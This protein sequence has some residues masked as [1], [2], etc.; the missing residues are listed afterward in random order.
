[1]SSKLNKNNFKLYQTEAQEYRIEAIP[2]F[3]FI[4]R[5]KELE[6]I[7]SAN[8]LSIEVILAKYYNDASAS[9]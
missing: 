5:S 1:M 6:R 4:R 8:T 7:R 3:V 2:T 9:S